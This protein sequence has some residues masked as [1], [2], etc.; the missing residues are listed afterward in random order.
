MKQNDPTIKFSHF[1]SVL[2]YLFFIIQCR[3][4][5][6][7]KRYEKYIDA[8][9]IT[10]KIEIGQSLSQKEKQCIDEILKIIHNQNEKENKQSKEKFEK[11]IRWAEEQ[12][13]EH[14]KIWLQVQY[15]QY[16]YQFRNMPQS[17]PIVIRLSDEINKIL[18][19]TSFTLKRVS[20]LLVITFPPSN[21]IKNPF[22]FLNNQ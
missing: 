5:D 16:L 1:I 12:N 11:A 13:Y 17:L 10:Q 6:N 18:K 14:L 4:N 2:F 20:D 3:S 21:N 9:T 22:I 8:K 15:A 7:S 19:K